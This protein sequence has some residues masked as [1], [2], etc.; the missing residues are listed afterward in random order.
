MR[1]RGEN[2]PTVI[3]RKSKWRGGGGGDGGGGGGGRGGIIALSLGSI[4][5]TLLIIKST[6]ELVE[7][8]NDPGHPV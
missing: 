1:W 8:I 5:R 2:S 4:V 6:N 3:I 7:L